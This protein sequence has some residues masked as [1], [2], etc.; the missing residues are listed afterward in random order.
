MTEI[1]RAAPNG[2][3]PVHRVPTVSDILRDRITALATEHWAPVSGSGDSKKKRKAFSEAVIDD[4]FDKELNRLGNLS[5]LQLLDFTCYLENYLW[6]NYSASSGRK[7]LLSI[8]MLINEKFRDGVSSAVA[9]LTEDEE[10]FATFFKAVVRLSLC[11]DS[12][13]PYLHKSFVLHFLVNIYQSLEHVAVRKACLPYLSLPL[14]LALSEERLQRELAAH[15]A[16]KKHWQ[17]LVQ[18][19]SSFSSSARGQSTGTSTAEAE[20]TETAPKKRG[21]GAA[22]GSK[23][24]K[25]AT[26]ASVAEAESEESKRDKELVNTWIP[27]LFFKFLE[28]V[29]NHPVDAVLGFHE[30]LY[31]EHFLEFCIDLLS[32]LPTRR[33]LNTFLADVHFVIRCRRSALWSARA[34]VCGSEG[35]RPLVDDAMDPEESTDLSDNDLFRRLVEAI[36]ALVHFEVQ[37]QTGKALSSVEVAGRHS[38]RLHHAQA[39][40]YKQYKE[41][42]GDS[43]VYSSIGELGKPET[44]KKCL[45]LVDMETLT[46]FS[47]DI[48]ALSSRDVDSRYFNSPGATPFVMDVLVD[49]LRLRPSQLDSLN[50]TPLYPTEQDLWDP[51]LIPAVRHGGLWGAPGDSAL[52]LPKLNLQFLTMHD[53][54]VRNF[55]L[56]KLES[57]YE[58]RQDLCD[59][60]RRMAPRQFPGAP[61]TFGGW[62]RMTVPVSSFSFSHIAKPNI[63]EECPSSVKCVVEVDISR[64][65]GAIREEWESFR[66][67]DVVFLITFEN[68]APSASSGVELFKQE[69]SEL[70]LGRR[71]QKREEKGSA[72]E[73]DMNF[74]KEFGIKYIRGAEVYEFRD[75]ENVVLNDFTRCVLWS[76]SNISV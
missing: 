18:T 1:I 45:E 21:R 32:Q 63:G 8:V 9:E 37:D 52:A 27:T 38:G 23:A 65:Q 28:F 25:T 49:Y 35:A 59:A 51:R 16:L 43:F 70:A 53:Y 41:A 40:A 44:I 19:K 62:S 36:D 6:P 76:K 15:P 74:P 46:N 17:H 58:I 60:I 3:V 68:P 29:E 2:G 34:E 24:K 4:I 50:Q 26:T 14:W 61:V 22:A 54:L 10:K 11:D 7:H 73:N 48:G 12:D 33:F 31:V 39:V 47:V 72:Y 69:R 71:P 20:E 5:R 57:A 30:R 66:E 67:H 42:I 56:F 55:T 13:L 75:E 64:Y